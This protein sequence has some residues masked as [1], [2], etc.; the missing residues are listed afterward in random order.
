MTLICRSSVSPLGR[1]LVH[2]G[3]PGL[4]MRDSSFRV[5]CIRT[6]RNGELESTV[7]LAACCSCDPDT[8]SKPWG[9]LA[10]CKHRPRYEA[11][12]T[13][14][15]HAWAY[16]DILK[17]VTAAILVVRRACRHRTILVKVP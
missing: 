12:R 11:F 5:Q 1:L 13:L 2:W 16:R 17:D 9:L 15:D 6:P 8:I 7:V 10:I 14:V 4:A 3:C